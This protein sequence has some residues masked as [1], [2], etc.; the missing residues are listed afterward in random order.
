MTL[1]KFCGKHEAVYLEPQ[2]AGPVHAEALE[3]RDAA[4]KVTGSN[5]YCSHECWE[6]DVKLKRK[7]RE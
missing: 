1:C 3:N 2:E 5:L 7:I 6:S 4:G